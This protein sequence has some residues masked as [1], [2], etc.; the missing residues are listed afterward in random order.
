MDG[1]EV[2]MGELARR[3]DIIHQ[4]VRDLRA[5][6]A[7]K[8]DLQHVTT[9]WDAALK[10]HE[11]KSEIQHTVLENRVKALESWQTWAIRI[12]LGIVIAAVVGL[13]VV[14]APALTR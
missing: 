3:M 4:D 2:T 7:E 12:V 9:A 5:A 10:A 11:A 14:N 13:V 8:D 1:T 6:V